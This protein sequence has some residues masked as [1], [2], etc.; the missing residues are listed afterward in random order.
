MQ[1]VVFEFPSFGFG[2][3]ST[4]CHLIR[5]IQN[6]LNCQVMVISSGVGLEFA[7]KTLKNVVFLDINTNY[8]RCFDVVKD[9]I[10]AGSI[11]VSNT[12][13]DFCRWCVEQGYSLIVIDTLFWMWEQELDFIPKTI[14]YIVQDYY[15]QERLYNKNYEK[16]KE[17]LV[18]TSPVIRN[19]KFLQIQAGN[20]REEALIS[21]GGMETPFNKEIIFPYC[22]YILPELVKRLRISGIRK[23]HIVGGLCQEYARNALWLAQYKD[24]V[25]VHG[26][27]SQDQY[28]NLLSCAYQF[29]TPGLTSIYE[30]Y[31][32]D[33][34]PYFLPGFSMSHILQS[35]SYRQITGYPFIGQ[36]NGL[37]KI[38]EEIST[39]KE[40]E[41]T[42]YFNH[43]L[44][45]CLKGTSPFEWSNW[46][47][48]MQEKNRSLLAISPQ[49]SAVK[50][51]W[52][53]LDDATEILLTTLHTTILNK[54]AIK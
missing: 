49:I 21:L 16:Y 18:I 9:Y 52:S 36:W 45:T 8:I 6:K 40:D 2:P 26:T 27:V 32:T 12:N 28:L 44:Q 20:N 17:Y 50:E 39:M 13:I 25:I 3:A 29:I 51:R 38:V 41:G 48:Y 24:M 30:A 15:V 4:S 46:T 35:E 43:F 53:Q 7:R 1:T 14:N 11:I 10:P 31:A 42:A 47:E 33:V 22:E 19:S 37:G 34:S 54:E 5:A 23:I